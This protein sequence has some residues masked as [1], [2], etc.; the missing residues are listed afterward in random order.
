MN[1][2]SSA[3]SAAVIHPVLVHFELQHPTATQV[4]IAGSFNDWH[5]SATPM[6]SMGG[7][8]WAKE[9]LLPPGTY[10]YRFV[11]DGA[12]ITDECGRQQVANPFGSHNTVLHVGAAS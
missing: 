7:G 6:V 8:R 9:I 5:S 12:W 4:C 1:K 2:K 11:V 3:K 10:E